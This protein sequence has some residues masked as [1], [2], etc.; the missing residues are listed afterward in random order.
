MIV[1]HFTSHVAHCQLSLNYNC[2]FVLS[3]VLRF[4]FTIALL[5]RSIRRRRGP[6]TLIRL[7]LTLDRQA[8]LVPHTRLFPR[9]LT[10]GHRRVRTGRKG[11]L[12]LER[13]KLAL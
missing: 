3:I 10:K 2:C 11:E 4:L 9:N 5:L 13:L 8:N 7:I 12:D 6:T 1:M